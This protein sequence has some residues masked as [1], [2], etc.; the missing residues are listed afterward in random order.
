MTEAVLD[1]SALVAFLRDEPGA[2]RVATVLRTVC[3]GAVNLAEALDVLARGK[4]LDAVVEQIDR[5]RIPV[6]PFDSE[7]AR[8][9]ASIV[10]PTRSW[11]LSLGDRACLAL[12]LS[13]SLPAFTTDRTWSQCELPLTIVQLR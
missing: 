3:I 1:A 11:G 12:A 5:L 7:L 10:G 9:T 6:V 13:R 4:P 2:D 8:I